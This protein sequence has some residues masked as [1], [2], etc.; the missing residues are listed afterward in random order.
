MS[1][2]VSICLWTS[3][4]IQAR[5][6]VVVLLTNGWA[7]TVL[8][9]K[10][11]EWSVSSRLPVVRDTSG[12]ETFWQRLAGVEKGGS[13][14]FSQAVHSQEGYPEAAGSGDQWGG[15]GRKGSGDST[16]LLWVVGLWLLEL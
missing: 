3:A 13:G 16:L 12:L 1:L 5:E 14:S 2:S 10:R 4:A 8:P 9:E 7:P 11:E 6:S 15:A